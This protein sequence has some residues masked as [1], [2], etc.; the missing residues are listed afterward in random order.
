MSGLSVRPN[1]LYHA[2]DGEAMPAPFDLNAFLFDGEPLW[3]R[4]GAQ[5]LLALHFS[6]VLDIQKLQTEHGLEFAPHVIGPF[7]QR[8]NALSQLAHET[9]D[10][11]DAI[12]MKQ[13]VSQMRTYTP[14]EFG[15]RFVPQSQ[16]KKL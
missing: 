8:Y 3:E 5:L 9:K 13:C 12:P 16:Y 15:E 11:V 14:R 2:G 1:G 6:Q 10:I 7:A 4:K